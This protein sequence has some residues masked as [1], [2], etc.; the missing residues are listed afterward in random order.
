MRAGEEAADDPAASLDHVA[1]ILDTQSSTL[2]SAEVTTPRLAKE[3]ASAIELFRASAEASR[4]ASVAAIMS[5]M[6]AIAAAQ[7]EMARLAK[8][9]DHVVERIG[10]MCL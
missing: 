4:K 7:R 3:V 10:T 9:G 1:D 8:Q 5:D 2:E 6:T